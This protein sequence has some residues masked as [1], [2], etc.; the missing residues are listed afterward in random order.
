MP[1]L[2]FESTPRSRNNKSPS[3]L[4]SEGDLSSVVCANIGASTECSMKKK[5]SNKCGGNGAVYTLSKVPQR[6]LTFQR[7]WLECASELHQFYF[8]NKD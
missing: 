7:P 5:L 6:S 2:P 4:C 8:L 3:N 1:G